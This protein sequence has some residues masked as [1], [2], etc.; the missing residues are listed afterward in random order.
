M[1]K[2]PVYFHRGDVRELWTVM[3]ISW[4][5]FSPRQQS[6]VSTLTQGHPWLDISVR[7]FLLKC[8]T[9]VWVLGFNIPRY[10][11][12]LKDQKPRQHL[13]GALH[14]NTLKKVLA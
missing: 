11:E 14:L 3:I 8:G 13:S 7:T 10:R 6:L 12:F 9:Q 4:I 2:W 5:I 1:R